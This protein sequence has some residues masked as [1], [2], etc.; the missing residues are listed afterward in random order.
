[1]SFTMVPGDILY[2]P[3]GFLHEATTSEEPSL[4]ITVTVPTSDY[5]WGVQLARNLTESI[6]TE[7][8]NEE[9]R[10]LC[11]TSMCQLTSGKEESGEKNAELSEKATQHMESLMQAWLSQV[12]LKGMMKSFESRMAQTNI[13]QE[14]S[15]AASLARKMPPRVTESCRIRLMYGVR[16]RVDTGRGLAIFERGPPVDKQS[17]RDSRQ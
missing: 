14:R 11:H 10:H 1:M 8:F 7:R 5:C 17:A 4:H 16:C 3:R 13:G 15:S 6:R 2:I 12:S 9:L